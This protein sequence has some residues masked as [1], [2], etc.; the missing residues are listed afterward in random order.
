MSNGTSGANGAE[1]EIV[2][3]YE[4]LKK[5][6]S[7]L[8]YHRGEKRREVAERMKQAMSFGDISENSEYDEAIIEQAEVE[9]RILQLESTLNNARIIDEDDVSTEK[10]GIGCKVRV[11][12]M[13]FDDEME[14]HIV[15][16][17]ESDPDEKK[18]SNESPVGSALVGQEVGKIV[19]VQAP[20]G[21]LKF[22]ILEITK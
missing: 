2:L 5:L 14:F 18:I 17:T 1:K 11:L 12:D 22:K 10:V 6:E 8:E 7:D 19:D 20:S 21:V 9:T 3:T 15:G 16:S 4:G 13:E